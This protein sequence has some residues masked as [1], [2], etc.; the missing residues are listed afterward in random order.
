MGQL[1]P[2]PAAPEPAAA[3]H[4]PAEPATACWKAEAGTPQL[5]VRQD[6][7]GGALGAAPALPAV[8]MVMPAALAALEARR[9]E[10]N[11][12]L[13]APPS[14]VVMP[15]HLSTICSSNRR[16]Y[17]RS[18][19]RSYPSR[20]GGFV[21]AVD[22]GSPEGDSRSPAGSG[23]GS[24]SPA[25]GSSL[26]S[27]T[28]QGQV[29]L[30][31]DHGASR[32][33]SPCPESLPANSPPWAA[34]WPSPATSKAAMAGPLTAPAG[35][36]VQS[37]ELA[38]ASGTDSGSHRLA[39]RPLPSFCLQ[40]PL[41]ANSAAK[42]PAVLPAG[43]QPGCID[44]PGQKVA[45]DLAAAQAPASALHLADGQMSISSTTRHAACCSSGGKGAV[46]STAAMDRNLTSLQQQLDRCVAFC[47]ACTHVCLHSHRFL[48]V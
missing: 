6:S 11:Q 24:G 41:A 32:A 46:H 8:G 33:V 26:I 5:P 25:S 45:A 4:V 34:A 31:T 43:A 37:L 15:T 3:A 9:A 39:P 7:D 13:S 48:T 22:S 40:Q 10:Q 35:Q 47:R 28:H 1:C 42:A 14:K 29:A 23:S 20:A 12:P 36:P 30:L 19:I 21:S 2:L 17:V 44:S 27:S 38:A 18:Y 16:S